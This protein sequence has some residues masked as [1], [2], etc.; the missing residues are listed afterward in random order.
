MKPMGEFIIKTVL[1]YHDCHLSFPVKNPIKPRNVALWQQKLCYIGS[2]V[3]QIRHITMTNHLGTPYPGSIFWRQCSKIY[4]ATI[5]QVLDQKGETTVGIRDLTVWKFHITVI[6]T[7]IITVISIIAVLLKC[8][9]NFQKVLIHTL[10]SFH[11]VSPQIKL[12]ALLTFCLH[13]HK[14]IT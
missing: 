3:W 10:K 1:H 5:D 7:K 4:V 14:I 11:P 9:E 2:C 6:V 8:A 13:K 12:A